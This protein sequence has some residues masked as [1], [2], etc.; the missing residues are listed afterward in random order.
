MMDDRIGAVETDT[1]ERVV[2][3][4]ELKAV[5]VVAEEESARSA[6]RRSIY[7]M[8]SLAGAMAWE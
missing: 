4:N 7:L 3:D 2:V 8:K 6:E 1:N 5:D